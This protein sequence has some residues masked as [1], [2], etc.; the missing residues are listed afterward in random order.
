MAD[1]SFLAWPFFEP[2][3]AALANGLDAWAADTV[4]DLV[5]H[6]YRQAVTAAGSGCQG[7]LDTEWYLRD[8]G[9]GG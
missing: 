3:H 8:E 4:G 9:L 6:T 5:D 1:R 2:H 7:A